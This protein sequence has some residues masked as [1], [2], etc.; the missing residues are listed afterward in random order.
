MAPEM[1]KSQMPAHIHLSSS[2]TPWPT[3]RALPIEFNPYQPQ[4]SKVQNG[5]K[6]INSLLPPC[7]LG[8]SIL[9]RCWDCHTFTRHPY[10]HYQFLTHYIEHLNSLYP[11]LSNI[12]KA[13]FKR[14]TNKLH[15]FSS[16]LEKNPSF[17]LLSLTSISVTSA[18]RNV[19]VAISSELFLERGRY[20]L[21]SMVEILINSTLKRIRTHFLYCLV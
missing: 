20:C 3:S 17:Y 8:N 11:L 21:I 16:F 1:V 12:L 19:S 14:S 5:F 13:L 6:N 7:W 18:K 9:L 2:P 15:V 4:E 10:F